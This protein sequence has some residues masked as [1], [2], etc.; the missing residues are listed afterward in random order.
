MDKQELPSPKEFFALSVE[1]QRKLLEKLRPH[2][3]F[4]AP[5]DQ[6]VF[7]TEMDNKIKKE[8]KNGKTTI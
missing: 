5:K 6:R 8:T 7:T 1:E 3:K 4:K 2:P